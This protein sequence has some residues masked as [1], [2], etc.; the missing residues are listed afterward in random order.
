MAGIFG[1]WQLNT[2]WNLQSGGLFAPTTSRGFGAGGDFNGDGQRGDRPN[3]PAAGVARS[4]SK[5]E[6]L[7]GAIKAS[8]FP[9]PDVSSGP[10]VGTLPRDYFRGPGYARIDAAFG[11]SFPVRI[12]LGE[13]ARLHLRAEA[14]NMLNRVNISGVSSNLSAGNFGTATGAF[15]MRVMQ[16][17]VKFVF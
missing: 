3:L 15:R 2:I 17:S 14:F 4:Y 16:L 9:L 10:Q 13:N 8:V 11:K 7:N 6:W 5:S 12:G 1:G